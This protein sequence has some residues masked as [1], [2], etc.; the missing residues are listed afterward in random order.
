[1]AHM[2]LEFEIGS[3]KTNVPAGETMYEYTVSE[4]VLKHDKITGR[5]VTNSVLG[6][7]CVLGSESANFEVKH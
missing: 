6:V 2:K 1:M 4:K 3:T 5:I 7:R